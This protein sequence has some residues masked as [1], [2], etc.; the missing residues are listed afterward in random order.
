M[1]SSPLIARKHLR[2]FN[3][4]PKLLDMIP[5]LFPMDMEVMV[6]MELESV[7]LKPMLNPAKATP[8]DPSA[9]TR[10]TGSAIRSPSRTLARSLARNAR[11]LLTPHTLRTAR[12]SSPPTARKPTRRFPT[13]QQLL[14]MT[15]RLCLMGMGAMGAMDT[16]VSSYESVLL[17]K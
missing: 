1:T 14:D 9:M 4:A 8:L 16:E 17:K 6:D 2:K 5:W 3:T 7:R 10:R 13:P 15:P 11:P 12:T